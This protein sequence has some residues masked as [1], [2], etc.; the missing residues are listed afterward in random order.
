MDDVVCSIHVM[1]LNTTMSRFI[2]QCVGEKW[3]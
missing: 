1:N 3:Q 2:F